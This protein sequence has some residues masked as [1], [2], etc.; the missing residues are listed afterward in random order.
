MDPIFIE[1]IETTNE[2]VDL[3][4]I[5]RLVILPSLRIRSSHN[6]FELFQDSMA[7][8][9]FH[10]HLDIFSTMTTIPIRLN[11]KKH[12]FQGKLLL[13]NQILWGMFLN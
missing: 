3:H 8:T 5:D 12:Y 4:K 1:S 7:I 6:M 13:I 9:H 11:S 2:D 10:Q